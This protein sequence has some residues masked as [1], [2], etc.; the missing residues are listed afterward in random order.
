[1]W[2]AIFFVFSTV[3]FAVGTVNISAYQVQALG[4]SLILLSLAEYFG[5]RRFWLVGFIVALAGLTRATLYLSL[6]FYLLEWSRLKLSK[7]TL[8]SLLVPIVISGLVLA[9]YNYKRFRS[10]T[11]TGYKYNVTLNSH[12][13]KGNVQYGFISP[14]HIPANLYVLLLK[15]PDPVLEPGGGFVFK[16]PFF[17]ADPWGMA[18]WFNSPLLFMLLKLKK[19]QFTKSSLL[20]TITLLIP[21]ITYSGIGYI[22]FGYRYALDFLPFLFLLLLPSLG[23]KLSRFSK[24]LILTGVIFNC[25]YLASLWGLYPHFFYETRFG[26]LIGGLKWSR[27]FY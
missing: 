19:N 9:G 22:Q 3:L 2:L 8:L 18:I 11:E 16:F 12:P 5:K 25:V 6:I 26:R 27:F 4:T 20:T 24:S 1:L 10:F 13:M 15:V 17:K 23:K 7:R 14:K 21:T